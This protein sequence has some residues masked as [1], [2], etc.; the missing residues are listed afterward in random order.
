MW[1]IV[2]ALVEN[3]TES[4]LFSAGGI[5]TFMFLFAYLSLFTNILRKNQIIIEHEMDTVYQK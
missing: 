2:L 1:F 5:V 3:F 4:V